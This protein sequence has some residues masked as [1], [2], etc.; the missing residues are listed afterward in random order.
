M[1][2]TSYAI[3]GPAPYVSTNTGGGNRV[4]VGNLE[5][6]ACPIGNA[7]WCSRPLPSF[8]DEGSC[9]AVYFPQPLLKPFS[10]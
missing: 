10:Y 1:H 7:D 6:N 9:W 4:Q 3:P 5:L 2:P 8:T